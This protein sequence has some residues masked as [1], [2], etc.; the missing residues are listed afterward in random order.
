MKNYNL[1]MMMNMCCDM[2]KSMYF[3]RGKYYP[4]SLSN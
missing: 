3:C 1:V 2:C 4:P